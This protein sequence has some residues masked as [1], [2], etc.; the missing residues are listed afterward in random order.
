MTTSGHVITARTASI[1]GGIPVARVLP[2]KERRSIGAWC[3]LD[4]AG[5]ADFSPGHGMRVGPHPHIGLQTF[6]WMIEGEVL[7]RDSL[8][9]EQ[10]IRPGQVNLM[11]AGYGISHSEECLSDETRL[12]AAQLWIALPFHAKN[13]TPAFNHYPELPVWRTQFTQFSLLAGK[14]GSYEAPTQ[15]FSPLVGLE[16]LSQDGDAIDLAL[17]TT[18]EYGILVL[19]GSIE[20]ESQQ[21]EKDQLIYLGEGRELVHISMT[22]NTRILLVGGEKFTH[23][24]IIWWNFVGYNREDIT[25][26]N[27][28]WEN[29]SARFGKVVGF[30]GPPLAAPPLPWETPAE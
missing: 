17:E 13:V 11:T 23:E 21:V 25:Q 8:G 30:D 14:Y 10:I 7:H 22:K 5:P 26:A 12:H 1:G 19:E 4:H 6:T 16:V 28:E 20:C 27:Q 24:I 18:F 15:T 9:S 2:S 29:G 3:F